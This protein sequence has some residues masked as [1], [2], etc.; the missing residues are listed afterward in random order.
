MI[1]CYYLGVITVKP[2]GGAVGAPHPVGIR[3]KMTS[4]PIFI[5]LHYFEVVKYAMEKIP[6]DTVKY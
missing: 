4:V 5:E 2:L 3:V 1:I 6:L